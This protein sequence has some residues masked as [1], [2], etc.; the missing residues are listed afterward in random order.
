MAIKFDIIKNYGYLN[1]AENK[2]VLLISWNGN[3]PKLEIRSMRQIDGVETPL[4]GIG[5]SANEVANLKA[6]LATI[7]EE[8]DV[9]ETKEVDFVD[10][11]EIFSNANDV[12]ESRGEASHRE[13]RFTRLKRRK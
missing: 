6:I 9:E 8:D 13:F 1:E 4:K 3:P 7:T 12:S 2:A 5:L 11:G 10:F